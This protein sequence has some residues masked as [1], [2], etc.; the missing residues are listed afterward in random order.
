[1]RRKIVVLVVLVVMGLGLLAASG[2]ES[3]TLAAVGGGQ[4][5]VI[6]RH[7]GRGWSWVAPLTT[8]N[9]EGITVLDSFSATAVGQN[10]AMG[11]SKPPVAPTEALTVMPTVTPATRPVVNIT[12]PSQPTVCTIDSLIWEATAYNPAVGTTNGAGID[13]VVFR[14]FDD[15]YTLVYEKVERRTKYCGFGG[16][17][18][19]YALPLSDGTWHAED[20]SQTV[21][22]PILVGMTY[23][24][25]ATAYST[26]VAGGAS[27]NN[28]IQVTVLNCPT[29]TPTSTSTPTWTPTATLTPTPTWTA[30]PTKTPL[31]VPDLS[32]SVKSASPTVVAYFEEIAY[33]ITVRNTGSAAAQVELI[34]P[35]PLS[36]VAGSATGGIWWDDVAGLIRW[37]GTIAA[38]DSRT[39]QFRVHG[40]TPPIAH[41]TIYTNRVILTDGVNPQIVRS[42]DVLANPSPTATSTPTATPTSTATPSQTPITQRQYLPLVLR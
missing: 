8:P 6:L 40:P 35:P 13:Q 22:G 33:T 26:Q 7:N 12:L 15:N 37:Q 18:D 9:L 42:I 31:G 14:I 11:H 20:N 1:M 4:A 34:D 19:C 24:L 3:P 5:D 36:Y 25:R 23:K 2:L 30:T 32:A 10:D 38:G 28:S 29:A 27:A 17:V 39:F 16:D 21:G 41:N